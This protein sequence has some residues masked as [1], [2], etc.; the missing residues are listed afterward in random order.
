MWT[1]DKIKRHKRWIGAGHCTDRWVINVI[2]VRAMG[3][4]QELSNCIHFKYVCNRTVWKL[5]SRTCQWII[6]SV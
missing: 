5:K 3:F 4:K 1:S 6:I 2:I